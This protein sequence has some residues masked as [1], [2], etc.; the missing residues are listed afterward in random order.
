MT[1]V[2]TLEQLIDQ[3]IGAN[4]ERDDYHS[5]SI[6]GSVIASEC[7]R[8][9]WYGFRWY[10]K[11]SFSPRMRRRFETGDTYETRV[12]E[13]LRKTGKFQILDKYE[14]A[15]NPSKQYSAELG[16]LGGLFRGHLDGVVIS[17]QETWSSLG[18]EGDIGEKPVLMEI[19]ALGSAKYEY[20]DDT[21]EVI[22]ANKKSGK[23]EGRWFELARQGCKKAQPRHYGQMQ[24]Y[25]GLSRARDRNGKV[26]YEKWGFSAP[27][28]WALYIGV[29]T[30]TDQWYAELVPYSP[31]WFD[32]IVQRVTRLVRATEPPARIS[33]NP[34]NHTCRFCD[35]LEICHMSGAPERNCRSC[36][37]CS[38]K[39][40]G[41][42]QHFG[43]TASFICG[44]HKSACED[45]VACEDWTPI[46]QMEVMF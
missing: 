30:D 18:A 16:S 35:Y 6:G 1:N 42:P 8:A 44:K 5:Y 22:V 17:N 46:H 25:M 28:D 21:Y 14:S 19:K 45:F 2:L 36:S 40:P 33:E 41:D 7:E 43:S 39:I 31:A 13:T 12:I 27:L 29:N 24:S 23:L 20:A 11:P 15:R 32:R 34:A 26:H 4:A 9:I 38:I 3:A 37:S 10:R